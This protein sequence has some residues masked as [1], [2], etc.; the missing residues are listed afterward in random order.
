M[1]LGQVQGASD[2]DRSMGS[3]GCRR[4]HLLE[5]GEPNGVS[6]KRR[7]GGNLFL[8]LLQIC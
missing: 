2:P 5:V 1:A 8:D 3:K 7:G 4:G 6:D